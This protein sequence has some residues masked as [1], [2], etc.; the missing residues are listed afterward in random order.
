MTEVTVT[1]PDELAARASDAGLL[2]DAAIQALLEDAMR[3]RAGR[4][5]LEVAAQI[6]AAAI[7][8]LTDAEIVA[9]VAAARAERR[10][11]GGTARDAGGS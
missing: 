8:P 7:P 4:R 10:R 3:R 1:L 2:S 6:H 9:E 11:G 5:L